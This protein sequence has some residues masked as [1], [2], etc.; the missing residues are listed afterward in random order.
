MTLGQIAYKAAQLSRSP[1]IG[2]AR[3]D[4]DWRAL[5][6]QNY[7]DKD[8]WEAVAAAISHVQRQGCAALCLNGVNAKRTASECA[9]GVRALSAIDLGL[10]LGKS[11]GQHAY[12]AAMM[13]RDPDIPLGR[14]KE[15]W[16]NWEEGQMTKSEWEVTAGVIALVERETCARLCDDSAGGTAGDC[17]SEIKKRFVAKSRY[18]SIKI[19]VPELMQSIGF[20]SL[21]ASGNDG[22]QSALS[23]LE[24]AIAALQRI[25][26]GGDADTPDHLT[27]QAKTALAEICCCDQQASQQERSRG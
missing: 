12:E 19:D 21:H 27:S 16:V 14:L 18:P 5:D 7:L 26:Q 3:L 17:V 13:S 20:A 15:E 25:A 10:S 4:L 1:G 22:K 6:D 24:I 11:P 8:D 2:L 9:S 23:K